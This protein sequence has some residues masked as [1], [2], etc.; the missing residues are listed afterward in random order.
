MQGGSWVGFGCGGILRI[1][2]LVSD[3]GKEFSQGDWE[4]GPRGFRPIGSI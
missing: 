2:Q 1:G 3:I 4:V